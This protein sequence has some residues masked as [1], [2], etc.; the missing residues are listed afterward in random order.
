MRTHLGWI[1]RAPLRA[2]VIALAA[3]LGY[4]G[5]VQAAPAADAD[6]AAVKVEL[7][8]SHLLVSFAEPMQ[9]WN[10]RVEPGT[11]RLEPAIGDPAKMRCHW[12][13]DTD[14]LCDFGEVSA[15][16]AT[17][18]RVHLAAGLSTQAGAVIPAQTHA[19]RTGLPV[20]RS[21][22]EWDDGRP[23]IRVWVDQKVRA[24]AL[25]RVLRLSIDG[26]R[27]PAQLEPIA[28]GDDDEGSRY[29]LR[30]PATL[31]P[32]TKIELA[33]E[34]GLR[35]S[36][37]PLP[38]TQ[39][40][41]LLTAMVNEPFRVIGAACAQPSQPVSRL[42]VQDRIELECMPGETVQLVFS[43]PLDEASR[44]AWIASWPPGMELF[45]RGSWSMY[46]DSIRRENGE[47]LAFGR[48]RPR[49]DLDL[50][51]QGLRSQRG[52]AIQPLNL[53]VRTLDYRP[54][55][56]GPTHR[57]LI[58]D[59]RKPALL[60]QAVNTEGGRWPLRGLD[61]N[62]L[63]GQQPG[64][65][66]RSA[67]PTPMLTGRADEVLAHDGW[68]AWYPSQKEVH[69]AN[70]SALVEAS[71]PAFDLFAL[72]SEAEV[73][74]WAQRWDDGAAVAGAE[75]ELLLQSAGGVPAR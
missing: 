57:A 39:S 33:V 23:D 44:L 58:A 54:M 73:L 13:D 53:H 61:Q 41:R 59:G 19:V 60:L 20:V 22:I 72:A 65:A 26:R 12:Q 14:L 15:A 62:W 67:T 6:R 48:D 7:D 24:D 34:P 5:A 55:L 38:G 40:D 50:S 25:A 64:P 70:P 1:G 63:Q 32:N 52:E 74:V 30:L 29:R 49:A 66:K 4:A 16:G 56:R 51:V 75:V 10:N 11:V 71:A 18:Y 68:L 27:V 45:R 36:E 3:W 2:G 21:E 47:T 46:R 42:P 8:E 17:E 28:D 69:D 43:Q 9:V 37:G 31:A 35:S